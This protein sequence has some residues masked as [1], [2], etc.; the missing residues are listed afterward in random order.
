[1]PGGAVRPGAVGPTGQ[2]MLWAILSDI[3]SNVAALDAVTRDLESRG[4]EGILCLGDVIGYGPEPLV[5]LRRA[6]DYQVTLLG[7]HEEAALYYPEDFNDRAR[8]ALEWTKDQL[9]CSEQA[10][11]WWDFL[12]H[13]PKHHELENALLV[14]GSPRDPVREYVVPRDSLN[15]EKME[16][17]FSLIPGDFCF[18]GHSHVPG[19]YL[20]STGFFPPAKLKH[21]FQHSQKKALVNVGSVGQPRDGDPRASYVTWDG[22]RVWFH[23]VEYDVQRT[24]RK[25]LDTGVL[26]PYLA[27]RLQHGR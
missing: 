15:A 8:I 22:S 23:R 18:V 7:N 10:S 20:E 21:G 6:M 2:L 27:N 12:G 9:N 17:I 5:T 4:V 13:L 16:E 14:H 26:P 24:Q 11:Q 1:M 25:I 3:H 19:V